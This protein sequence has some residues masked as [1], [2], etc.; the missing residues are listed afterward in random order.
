MKTFR[1]V[2]LPKP[3]P[4]SSFCLQTLPY[5]Q[6]PILQNQQIRVNV[7]ACAVAYRDIIDRT[8]QH[9]PPSSG[10]SIIY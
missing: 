3:G 4:S 9:S 1:R 10:E 6:L 2:L 5:D 8:G 7:A